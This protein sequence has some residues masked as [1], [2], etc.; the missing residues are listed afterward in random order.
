LKKNVTWSFWGI[1][2]KFFWNTEE[3]EEEEK[4]F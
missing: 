3:E 1:T 2:K 4:M